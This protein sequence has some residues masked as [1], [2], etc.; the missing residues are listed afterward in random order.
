MQHTQGDLLQEREC[1]S[2][3]IEEGEH[4]IVR[5]LDEINRMSGPATEARRSLLAMMDALSIERERLE[6]LSIS[7]GV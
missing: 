6:A 4:A 5:R 3:L 1:L 2:R 7:I